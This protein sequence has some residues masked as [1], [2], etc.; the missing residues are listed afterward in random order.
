MT[1][2]TRFLYA[3]AMASPISCDAP[4]PEISV[5]PIPAAERMR[6]SGRLNGTWA[7]IFS[8]SH[9]RQLARIGSGRPKVT[10]RERI[11][12]SMFPRPELWIAMAGRAPARYAPADMPT[13]SSSRVR[14]MCRN[15]PGSRKKSP[16]ARSQGTE[17]TRSIP[18]FL[19]SPMIWSSSIVCDPLP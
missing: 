11:A 14:P 13:P 16:F 17:L 10:V 9:P 6:G 4:G 3:A 8:P 1:C 18:C 7:G 2:G 19:S 15:S 5:Q 12:L